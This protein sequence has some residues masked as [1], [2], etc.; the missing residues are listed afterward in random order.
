MIFLE[1]PFQYDFL[2]AGSQVEETAYGPNC[3]PPPINLNPSHFCAIMPQVFDVMQ[4][5]KKTYVEH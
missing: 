3:V 2:K 4:T 5:S 1:M